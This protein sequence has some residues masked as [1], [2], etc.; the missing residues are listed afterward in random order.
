MRGW[1]KFAGILFPSRSRKGNVL[2]VRVR[3]SKNTCASTER[4][5][6]NIRARNRREDK[7]LLAMSVRIQVAFRN[8]TALQSHIFNNFVNEI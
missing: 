8:E 5:T 4:E 2:G 7:N 6:A 1:G 3:A